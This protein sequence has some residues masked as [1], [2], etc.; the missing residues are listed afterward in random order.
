[1]RNAARVLTI[2]AAVLA[3]AVP[4]ASAQTADIKAEVLKDW[5]GMKDTIVKL[6]SEMPEDK[7]GFKPTPPQRS[8][9]E[10]VLHVASTNLFLLGL[11]GGKA[12]PPA[13][14]AK[15]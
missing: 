8:Y 9:G 3:V 2:A 5:M 4:R 12:K 1:M 14:N 15:A 6:A 13:I 7:Y 10:Q 11:V